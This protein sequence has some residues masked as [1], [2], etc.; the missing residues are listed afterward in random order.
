MINEVKKSYKLQQV[1]SEWEWFLKQ[2]E[3]AEP[4]I[5]LEIG[6]A[7]GASS[8]CLSHFTDHLISID[9]KIP[10][11]QDVFKDIRK[12]C[13]FDFIPEQ[14]AGAKCLRQVKKALR[15]T[16]VDVLFI[17]GEH[18]YNGAK[19]DFKRFKTKARVR[20]HSEL[21]TNKTR[22]PPTDSYS[23]SLRCRAPVWLF[24]W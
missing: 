18:S 13:K 7:S 9:K 19:D 4:K 6:I 15:N 14:S 21:N 22:I 16:K 20:E 11:N 1:V 2:V 10:R 5:I 17:D 8:L 24:G 23:G 12:N 3:Q